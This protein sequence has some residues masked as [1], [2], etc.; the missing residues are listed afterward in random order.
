MLTFSWNYSVNENTSFQVVVVIFSYNYLTTIVI[1]ISEQSQ[2][3][4]QCYLSVY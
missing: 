3:D 1:P 2:A 4:L